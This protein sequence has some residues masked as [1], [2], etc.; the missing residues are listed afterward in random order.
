MWRGKWRFFFLFLLIPEMYTPWKCAGDSDFHLNAC[1]G[2]ERWVVV[3]VLPQIHKSQ[4][5]GNWIELEL[6][7]R[8]VINLTQALQRSNLDLGILH[9][10]GREKIRRE[11]MLASHLL[12]RVFRTKYHFVSVGGSASNHEHSG[13]LLPPLECLYL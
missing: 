8:A 4:C 10:S 13:F 11:L 7:R 3:F 9:T 5:I 2:H 12:I 1:Q 6:S